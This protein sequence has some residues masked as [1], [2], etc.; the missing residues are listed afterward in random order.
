VLA[1]WSRPSSRIGLLL[2]A[3]GIAYN[4]S[5]YAFSRT[6]VPAAAELS[7]LTAYLVVALGVQV[8]LSYPSGRLRTGY[9]RILVYSIYFVAGPGFALTYLFHGDGGASCWFCPANGFLITPNDTLDVDTTVAWFII[10]GTLVALAGLRSVPRWLAASPAARRSLAPVYITRWLA[11]AVLVL[12]CAVG[13]GLLFADTALW[14][15]RVNVLGNFSSVAVAA[16]IVV[17]FM[18]STA[19]RGAAGDLARVLQ[20]SNP[21]V[22]G[23]LQE[24]IRTVL[25][26]PEG[27]LLFAHPHKGG[28]LNIDGRPAVPR[29]DRSLTAVA[30]GAAIEHD[31]VLDDDPGVVE[32]VAAVAQLALETERLRALVRAEDTASTASPATSDALTEL[33]TEREREV[34]ALAADGLTD[35]AIA[36]RL[37]VTRRTVETHLGH[38]FSKLDVPAGNSNNRRVHAVRRFLQATTEPTRHLLPAGE[39][40]GGINEIIRAGQATAR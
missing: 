9:D 8:L 37:Y 31:S 21:L 1:H 4:A 32:S 5:A 18:R 10:L 38:I 30:P 33:L 35:T 17:V 29:S 40:D 2:I 7:T 3:E 28:W 23:R 26:D 14:T 11:V 6:S 15:V 22:P 27:R 34:L 19:A 39:S 20:T 36:Q 12:Y 24:A 16:G 13:A 25:H